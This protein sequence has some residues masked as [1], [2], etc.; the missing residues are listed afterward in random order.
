[1]TPTCFPDAP[2]Q[3][4][5]AS[6]GS[7]RSPARAA[8]SPKTLRSRTPPHVRSLHP[9]GLCLPRAWDG[10]T[11]NPLLPQSP[12]VLGR[13]DGRRKGLAGAPGDPAKLI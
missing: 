2:S 10:K 11:G 7:S 12:A 6:H 13:K 8:S 3:T 9:W 1:M 5:R 4:I